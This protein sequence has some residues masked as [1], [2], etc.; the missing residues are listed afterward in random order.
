MKI[1]YKRGSKGKEVERLQRKLKKL[2]YY[3]GKIDGDFGGGTESAVKRFQ[4]DNGLKVDGIVGEET[5]DAL[6]KKKIPK[7]KIEKEPLIYRCLALTGTFETGKGIPDCFA[8]ISGNFDGQGISFGV[9]QWNFGQGSLQPLLKDMIKEHR[10][11]IEG[12][13]NEYFPVLETALNS[14]KEE[15][16]EFALSIQHPV[17]H[18]IYEPWRGMFKSLG[19]TKEFQNI[20]TKYAQNLFNKALNL[21]D[22]YKLWSERAVALMFDIKTQNG[23][24]RAITKEQIFADYHNLSEDLPEEELEVERM[25]IVANRRAE[26]SNPRWVEDVRKRKLCIAN[27]GGEVHGINFNL[28]EQFGIKLKR[29]V[30]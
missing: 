6:F 25:R 23:S 24:I 10:D 15:L 16:M 27:G 29:Y 22:E 19:R 17:K 2:G 5:W 4:R 14:D 18:F 11:V 20:E 21:V 8:G 1:L 13:F 12:I 26:A 9:L 3:L 30:L 7:P 28:E